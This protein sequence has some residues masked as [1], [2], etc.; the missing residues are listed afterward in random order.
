MSSSD[1]IST[2]VEQVNAAVQAYS[3]PILDASLTFQSTATSRHSLLAA[4]K[5]LVTSLEDPEEEAWR[6]L[7]QPCAHACLT[8]A[9]Q[10]GILNQ[11]PKDVM[12]AKELAEKA[13]ADEKLVGE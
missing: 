9:W 3:S 4:A 10:C 6:F 12:T 7:L 11:W 8:S 1:E 13:N 2:L 5:S